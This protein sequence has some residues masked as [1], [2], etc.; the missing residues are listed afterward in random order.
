MKAQII[1]NCEGRVDNGFAF[2]SGV[3]NV[4]LDLSDAENTENY[5]ALIDYL[6]NVPK[7]FHNS[8]YKLNIITNAIAKIWELGYINNELYSRLADFYKFHHRCGLVLS[9]EPKSNTE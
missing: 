1:L 2:C 6:Y 7:I 9:I 5:T 4:I 3:S 8:C